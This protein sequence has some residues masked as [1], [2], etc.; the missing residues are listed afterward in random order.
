MRFIFLFFTLFL[1]A[2][3]ADNHPTSST[4]VTI[5][6]A[7]QVATGA[8][9]APG[10]IPLNIQS[11]RIT[12]INASG[13]VIAGPRVANRPNFFATL[14]T[15]NGNQ[16]R[17]RIVAFDAINAQG[18]KVYESLSQPFNL[19][20]APIVVNLTMS[21]AIAVTSNSNQVFRG[22]AVKIGRASCRE[23]V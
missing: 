5:S 2:C 21:L 10:Q 22:D 14:R 7:S 12:A 8:I 18:I 6:L 15:P 23:R 11:I 3:S 17:F 13:Q 1:A 16:I 9:G 4:D 19:T 20:G